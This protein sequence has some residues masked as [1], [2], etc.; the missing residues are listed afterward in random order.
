MN[1]GPVRMRSLAKEVSIRKGIKDERN[2]KL[3]RKT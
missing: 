1:M 3:D 2:K